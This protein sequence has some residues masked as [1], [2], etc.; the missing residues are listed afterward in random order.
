MVKAFATWSAVTYSVVYMIG[1]QFAN[2]F[3]W[4]FNRR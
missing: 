2:V 1:K 4:H 3:D